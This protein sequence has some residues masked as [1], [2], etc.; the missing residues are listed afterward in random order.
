MKTVTQILI[1]IFLFFLLG[2]LLS[3]ATSDTAAAKLQVNAVR[4]VQSIVLDGK[5]SEPVW[6]DDL[7]LTRFTQRDPVEGAQPS[8][9]TAVDVLYDDDAIYIGARMYDS[10]PKGI[11]A[12][13]GRK[14]VDLTADQFTVY[15]D[16]YH[17][18]RTGYYFSVN[19]AG[20]QY[21]GTLYNDSWSDS[22][23]DGVW[24]G[25]AK[26]DE[27]GWTIEMRIPYSQ[28]RFQKSDQYI[29]GIN[30]KRII[31][32]KNE[33]VYLVFQPKNGNGFVS[34]FPDLVGIENITP[35]RRLEVI[36]YVTGKASYTNPAGGD[37]FHDGS[38]YDPGVGADFKLGLGSNLTLSAT[39][40][41][42][43]GQVEV[44]PAVV[45]LSDVET[46]FDE[47]RPFFIEGSS[48][49]D[50]GVGGANSY[51]GFNWSNPL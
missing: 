39:A 51:W 42:D 19:A 46:F 38:S 14:D 17:D 21:D 30:F 41:P 32:R 44:D 48:I 16:P 27:K 31:A 26:I 7:A 29:W 4:A 43:F 28:L 49:F 33:N 20:T 23:W 45:N 12:L 13:L 18:R 15:I 10:N 9:K 34:R 24:E 22:S 37:P 36:P 47:K 35:R 50:F 11:I 1:D 2:N 6:K 40:N 3:A 25:I 8:E 5:L